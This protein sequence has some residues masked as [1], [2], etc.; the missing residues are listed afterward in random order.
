VLLIFGWADLIVC[1]PS[2]PKTKGLV[3]YDDDR[4]NDASQRSV[5]ALDS[6]SGRGPMNL[7]QAIA[8]RKP[9]KRCIE[10]TWRQPHHPQVL[11]YEDIIAEDY[12]IEGS[13]PEY[14]ITAAEL[15]QV[16]QLGIGRE[17]AA[18]KRMA[19][20]VTNRGKLV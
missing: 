7:L 12:E 6:H 9:F 11:N 13:T 18:F 10:R 3:I 16:Y 4:I 19:A 14:A 17:H 2:F 5:I 1:P 15:N 20:S 8:V